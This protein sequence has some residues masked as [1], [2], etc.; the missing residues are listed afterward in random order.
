M[1]AAWT[2]RTGVATVVLRPV[3]I[4]TDE[5][6]AHRSDA[7]AELGAFVHV[8]DVVDAAVRAIEAPLGGH[9]RV[10]LCGPGPFDT[11]LARRLLGWAPAR[12]GPTAPPGPAH[13]S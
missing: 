2:V 7:T 8:D 12:V 13:T 10:T 9:H 5:S 3:M 6:L 11:T 1:C 4:L